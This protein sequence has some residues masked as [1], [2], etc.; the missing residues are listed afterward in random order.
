MYSNTDIIAAM[1]RGDITISNF[2]IERLG[3]NSYDVLL[4]G[5]FLEVI[6]DTDGPWYIRQPN[7]Q[8][9]DIVRLPTGGTLLAKT[10]DRVGMKGRVTAEMSAR[11]STGKEAIM[12]CKCA[13]LGDVGFNNHWV[14]ELSGLAR[15][16]QPFVIVGEPIAQ[17]AFWETKSPPSK[18]YDGQYTGEDWPLCM[19]PK[20]WRHRIVDEGEKYQ[21]QPVYKDGKIG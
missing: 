7:V 17:L 10:R 5:V 1:E 16:G 18:I 21:V 11:S 6:W 19:V 13:G 2:D 12:V 9:G 20:K 3:P 8:D 4:D 14:M 15:I